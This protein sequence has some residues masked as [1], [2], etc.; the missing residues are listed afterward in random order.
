MLARFTS[1]KGYVRNPLIELRKTMCPCNS[2][3]L[4]KYCCGKED[5][6]PEKDALIIRQMLD[7]KI[8]NK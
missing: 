6:I 3:R 5:Y 4:A 7:Y 2:D 1:D 8:K